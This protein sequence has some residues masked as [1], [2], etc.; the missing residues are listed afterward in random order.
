LTK[1]DRDLTPRL[2]PPYHPVF[3][4]KQFGRETSNPNFIVHTVTIYEEL[5]AKSKLAEIVS[6]PERQDPDRLALI[7]RDKLA[8]KALQKRH[9]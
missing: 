8:H 6:S 1:P 5:R 9:P 4:R 2:C 7:H 3:V